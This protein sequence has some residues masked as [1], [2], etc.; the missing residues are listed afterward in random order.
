MTPL[1]VPTGL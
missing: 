1:S